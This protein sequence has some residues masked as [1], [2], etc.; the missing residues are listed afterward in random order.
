MASSPR[1]SPA[2]RAAL[3][4][5]RTRLASRFGAALADVC[6]FGSHARGEARESSDVDVLVVLDDAGAAARRDALDLAADVS[7]DR[8]VIL[9]ATVLGRQTFDRWRRERRPL[10]ADIE[11]D[12][13]RI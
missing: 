8:G 11:R 4:D 9:S 12:G 1:I 10:I 2:V 7:L 5:F 6:P 3:G 13:V